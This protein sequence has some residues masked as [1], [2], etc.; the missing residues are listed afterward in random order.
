MDLFA[1]L[2]RITRALDERGIPY[3]LVGGLAVAVHGVPRATADIDLLIRPEHAEDAVEL[4]KGLGFPFAALPL[5]FSDG[6]TLRR[7]TR[8]EDG[9]ALSVDL[10]LV[11]EA[12]EPAWASRER[13]DT[14]MGPLQVIGREALVQMK[15]GAGRAQ[16][17]ADVERLQ[18][19]DR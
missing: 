4:I 17:L 5:T 19:I 16:D 11:N 13:R 6:M 7:V 12:L 1:T 15:L 2:G 9:E 8:I 14:Q 10:L 3:A 18:E